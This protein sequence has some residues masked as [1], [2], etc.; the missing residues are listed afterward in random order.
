LAGHWQS[1]EATLRSGDYRLV[2]QVPDAVDVIGRVRAWLQQVEMPAK[3]AAGARV[4]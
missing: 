3:I 1:F 4:M 2:G